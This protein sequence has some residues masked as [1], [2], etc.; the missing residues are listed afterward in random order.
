MMLI[1]FLL[2]RYPFALAVLALFLPME[3]P[4]VGAAIAGS[5]GILVPLIYAGYFLAVFKT[6]HTLWIRRNTSIVSRR[7]F[8]IA[9]LA[10]GASG[11]IALSMFS[12]DASKIE[13]IYTSLGAIPG[14]IF[15]LAYYN[16]RS[17]RIVLVSA[18]AVHLIVG[19]GII[20][21]PHSPLSFLRQPTS[22]G[23]ALPDV[24]RMET[25]GYKDSAQFESAAQLAFYAAVGLIV[26]ISLLLYHRG[27]LIR[28]LG[29][30]LAGLGIAA[31]FFTLERGVWIGIFVG[32]IALI[33][34]L[35]RKPAGKLVYAVILSTLALG[36]LA[37]C[38]SADNFVLVALRDHFLAVRQDGYRIPVAMRSMD[39]LIAKPLFGVGGQILDLIDLAGGAPHQSFYFYAVTYGI[40]T[41]VCVAAMTWLSLVTNFAKRRPPHGSGL[42]QYDRLLGRTLG[43]VVVAMALTN[44]MSGGML[45]W[46]FLGFACLPWAHSLPAGRPVASNCPAS[47]YSRT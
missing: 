41:G 37:V 2:V 23:A 31:T 22:A 34:P 4:G 40:P 12:S 18:V 3:A 26:G 24:W 44:G 32:L 36:V 1:L 29:T 28:V 20:V 46:A 17:A 8:Q 42:T 33:A 6:L 10:A 21:F 39:I 7:V 19:C 13:T 30:C 25:T 45:G 15:A 16:N 47:A 14:V 11:W 27:T 35:K 38:T 43:L 5:F 9:L